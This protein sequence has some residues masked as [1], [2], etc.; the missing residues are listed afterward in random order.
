MDMI[1]PNRLKGDTVIYPCRAHVL[2]SHRLALVLFLFT[3]LLLPV[4]VFADFEQAAPLS[5]AGAFF[6]WMLL[7]CWVCRKFAIGGWLLFYF[8]TL[9]AG[10]FVSS[11]K[12]I[13]YVLNSN[14]TSWNNS[15]YYIFSMTTTV[16]NLLLQLAQVGL[17]Y[18]MLFKS[19]WDWRHVEIMKK[20]L[21]ASMVFA[22]VVAALDISL[23]PQGTIP[24]I[25]SGAVYLTW[26][27]YFRRS[28]RVQLVYKD[29]QWDWDRLHAKSAK[30]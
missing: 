7:V 24:H 5:K 20:V 9:Y 16:L 10:V 30:I 21:L 25:F 1:V 15:F 22:V 4:N 27:L 12:V 8:I 28:I 23:W 11:M 26:L 19:R 6:S 29:K 14:L 13:G 18:F 17:T 3:V 2:L